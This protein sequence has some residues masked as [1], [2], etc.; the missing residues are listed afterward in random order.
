MQNR[1]AQ[2]DVQVKKGL[3]TV[4]Y[5]L[6]IVMRNLA[7]ILNPETIVIGGPMSQ[8]ETVL[9]E[10]AIASF[11]AHTQRNVITP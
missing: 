4:G 6:G 10:P 3:E 1:L 7:N 11:A 2:G 8:F 9:L 5:F